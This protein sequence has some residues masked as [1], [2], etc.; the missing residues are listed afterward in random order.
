MAS[1]AIRS[2]ASGFV[3]VYNP[4]EFSVLADA[5]TLALTDMQY[6]FDI[7]IEN[8][9]TPTYKRFEVEPDPDNSYGNI[10]IA[11]YCE[12]ACNSVQVLAFTF[13]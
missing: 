4:I 2:G 9:S 12:S 7:Y 1:I 10:D 6:I 11:R 3:P 8:V 5:P 13:S